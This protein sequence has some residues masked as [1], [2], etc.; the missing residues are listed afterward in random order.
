MAKNSSSLTAAYESLP[1]LLKIIIQLILGAIV[2]GIYRIV[3]FFETGSVV[4]LV[5][6]LLVT[7]TG[8]GNLIAWICDL[9]TEILYNRISIL[10]D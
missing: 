5:V 8:I 1:R 2:G 10:A 7:F 9:V 6:G 4:T 3:K